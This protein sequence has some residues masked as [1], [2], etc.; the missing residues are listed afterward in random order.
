MSERPELRRYHAP[1]WDEP[2]LM[3][4]GRPGRRGILIPQPEE[5]VKELVGEGTELVAPGMRRGEK[6]L[7]PVLVSGRGRPRAAVPS[8]RLSDQTMV[9]VQQL[10]DLREGVRVGCD[11]R[12]K[13]L[14]D[15]VRAM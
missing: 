7:L 14:H 2:I 10:H 12:A 8:H 3:E 6:P 1:V 9:G 4:M 15:R 5:A 13:D 11:R